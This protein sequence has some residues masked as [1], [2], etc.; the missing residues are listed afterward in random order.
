MDI[1]QF[2]QQ[3]LIE[4][5]LILVPVL[6]VIGA[7]LKKTPKVSSWSIPW[8]LFVLGIIGGM[9]ILGFNIYGMMQGI[10]ASGVAVFAH[11]LYKQAKN[12]SA[13]KRS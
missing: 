8:I 1:M 10:I 6:M 7:F 4:Q 13:S 11:Q 12:G 2:F 5:A 9:L 3:F